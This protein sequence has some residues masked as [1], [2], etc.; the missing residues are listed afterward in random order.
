[1]ATTPKAQATAQIFELVTLL[2]RKRL[3]L[4]YPPLVGLVIAMI[5]TALLP[6][7]FESGT[8]IEIKE[9]VLLADGSVRDPRQHP[10][11]RNLQ[12]AASQIQDFNL[13]AQVV[14]QELQ[15]PS[16]SS[17]AAAGDPYLLRQY[18]Q[19]LADRIIVGVAQKKAET[20]DDRISIAF[21]DHDPERA[22]AFVEAIS[23]LWRRQVRDS[24]VRILEDQFAHRKRILD[25]LENARTTTSGQIDRI[26]AEG[27]LPIAAG[28][29]DAE[30][31]QALVDPEEQ[32]LQ[33]R[34][35][36]L[37]KLEE[38]IAGLVP[39]FEQAQARLDELEP[40][41]RE[42][43]MPET[44][45]GLPTETDS[46]RQ[47]LEARKLELE[48][49]MQGRTAID[50]RVRKKKQLIARIDRQL[51]ELGGGVVDPTKAESWVKKPNPE[52]KAQRQRVEQL[53][54]DLARQRSRAEQ[55]KLQVRDLDRAVAERKTSYAAVRIAKERY[56][57]LGTEIAQAKAEVEARSQV[58]RLLKSERG[59]PFGVLIPPIAG[60]KPV[61]PNTWVLLGI[62]LLAGLIFG[63]T[64]VLLTEYGRLSF[65][66]VEDA[67]TWLDVP[68]LGAVNRIWTVEEMKER[69]R[70]RRFSLAIAALFLGAVGS[71]VYLYTRH[72]DRLPQEVTRFLDDLIGGRS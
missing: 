15:W 4:V 52:W 58:L 31:T 2:Q 55:L 53:K 69:R 59:D 62:G 19:Q 40:T 42:L 10:I 1:M 57:E 7:Q 34:R 66:S 46:L 29:F 56:R 39:T 70:S 67:T 33:A 25:Q 26:V 47:Q 21:H 61:W 68:I 71:F 51:A 64:M 44:P 14:G 36:E 54:G 16:Y 63:A 12:N 72:P 38:E 35:E 60:R 30:R 22:R 49:E 43:D 28:D 32:K 20:G 24:Y 9:T 18:L 41:V 6:K 3:W 11:L 48:Q 45:E 8:L 5:V 13:I 27:Q 50:P 17:T 23:A 65:R 37:R